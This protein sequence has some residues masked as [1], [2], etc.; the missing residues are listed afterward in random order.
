[1][2]EKQY[3]PVYIPTRILGK[4]VGVYQLRNT[5]NGNIYIGSSKDLGS[6]IRQHFSDLRRGRH[7]SRT[8]PDC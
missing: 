5:L 4:S 8:T 7:R 6:R 3:N 2:E 1:M